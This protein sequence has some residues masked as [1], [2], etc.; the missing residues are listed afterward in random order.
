[1]GMGMGMHLHRKRNMRLNEQADRSR[2]NGCNVGI[3]DG[4]RKAH[5]LSLTLT[6]G[7]VVPSEMV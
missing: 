4:E 1:M 7:A 5:T 2:T 6:M 3:L